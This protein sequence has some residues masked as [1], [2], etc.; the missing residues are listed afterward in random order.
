MENKEKNQQKMIEKYHESG[1][2]PDR[3]YYQL[4]D[5]DINERHYRQVKAIKDRITKEKMAALEK[6]AIEYELERLAK[7][8]IENELEELL[9]V[10]H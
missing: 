9:K 7:S 3:Y 4:V 8:T 2:L 5:M 1:K 6:E 10:F